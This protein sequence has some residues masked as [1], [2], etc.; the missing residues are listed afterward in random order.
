MCA[1]TVKQDQELLAT[2]TKSSENGIQMNGVNGSHENGSSKSLTLNP[3]M[4]E[5]G[6]AGPSSEAPKIVVLQR[7]SLDDE[8]GL[9]HRCACLTCR[10]VPHPQ[11]PLALPVGCW[12]CLP[13]PTACSTRIYTRERCNLHWGSQGQPC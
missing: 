9:M 11:H 13:F 4:R 8:P 12:I 5:G 6:D 2:R 7:E 1:L 3:L 10:L